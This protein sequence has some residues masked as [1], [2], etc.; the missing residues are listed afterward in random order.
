MSFILLLGALVL[1]SRAWLRWRPAPRPGSR[2]ER[3]MLASQSAWRAMR[4]ACPGAAVGSLIFP[5]G[6]LPLS[7]LLNVTRIA[8]VADLEA[9]YYF[10][11]VFIGVLI[12]SFPCWLIGILFA[13]PLW[14]F[15]CR[16]GTLGWWAGAS[17]GAV[18][19]GVVVQIMLSHTG[20]S[21]PQ[22]SAVLADA[23]LAGGVSGATTWWTA[24]R[25]P[26]G[27]PPRE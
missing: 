21:V 1:L 27:S 3:R 8:A 15:L 6:L 20:L 9:I 23:V 14:D 19:C 10:G 16:W 24:Y 2:R 11:I 12:L 22:S 5:T 13:L 17:L 26:R 18:T 25:A 4:G 7:I